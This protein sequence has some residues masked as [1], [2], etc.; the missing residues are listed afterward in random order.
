[1]D[2]QPAPRLPDRPS[3]R[4]ALAVLGAA[5]A[6]PLIA[7]AQTLTTVS[8][9]GVPEDSI[10]PVLYAQQSGIFRR[11]GLDVHVEVQRSG[12]AV[13][14]GVAGGAYQIGKA[15]VTPLII[16]HSQGLPFVILAPA[17]IYNA[18]API[19]G[20][21]VKADSSLKN[22]ADLNGKTLAVLGLNDVFTVST[23]L[24]MDK[25][26]GDSSSIKF[27]EIPISA[28]ADAI[29]L[30]RIDAGTINEPDL[31]A[32][33]SGGKVRLF[34]HPLA[35]IAPRY[36]YTAW[37]TNASWANDHRPAVDGFVR[38]IREAA[39]YANSHHAQTV[40]LISDFTK[41]DPAIVRKMTRV[42][43][44]LGADPQMIAP[45]IE[46]MAKYKVIKAS[47]EAREL[48]DPGA[49]NR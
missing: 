12:P 15:S 3:R 17:G 13:A 22:P 46:A 49:L 39:V 33:L 23:K 40:D 32:A 26:G 27:V 48:I 34:A 21:M 41:V 11:Y 29:A 10:T 1:V 14:A 8:M 38:A 19:D 37:F 42:E 43:A 6:A 9:A 35:A 25:N 16:A 24:W 44:G 36:F 45:V 4:A 18:S 5:L 47:F 31:E 30:G 7:G 2:M 20:M 28:M